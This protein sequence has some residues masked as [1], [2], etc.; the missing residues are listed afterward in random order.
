MQ[1]SNNIDYSNNATIT[2]FYKFNNVNA[3]TPSQ[4]VST[5]D[6]LFYFEIPA[7]AQAFNPSKCRLEFTAT[8]TAWGNAD[9]SNT[10]LSCVSPVTRA[11]IK[12]AGGQT[13]YNMS[14]CQSFA[15][16]LPDRLK[17]NDN[18][19]SWLPLYNG[20]CVNDGGTSP[21]VYDFFNGSVGVTAATAGY[22]TLP[23][24]NFP[25]SANAA[26][27]FTINYRLGDLLGGFW[28]LDK[29]IILSDSL[30]VNLYLNNACVGIFVTASGVLGTAAKDYTTTQV[31]IKVA[32]QQ[33]YEINNS[34][35]AMVSTEQG[36]IIPFEYIWNFSYLDPQ[37]ANAHDVSVSIRIYNMIGNKLRKIYIIPWNTG[38]SATGIPYGAWLLTSLT[39]VNVYLDS[40]LLTQYDNLKYENLLNCRISNKYWNYLLQ[41]YNIFLPIYFCSDSDNINEGYNVTWDS[42]FWYIAT[43]SVTASSISHDI[44]A[45]GVKNLIINKNGV[46]IA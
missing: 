11:E 16:T 32:Y 39:N 7:N 18:S 4:T 41:K 8:V 38:A 40:N 37:N 28:D 46:L 5:N 13:I 10:L 35:R 26:G 33:N 42:I 34:I 31:F 22:G 20:R 29:D 24:N 12:T 9:N 19:L 30:Y 25:I 6:T 21:Y 36:L 27:T 15:R 2:G 1:V 43:A 3:S 45:V 14:K 23:A 17:N 44:F